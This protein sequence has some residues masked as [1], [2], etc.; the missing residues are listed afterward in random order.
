MESF[1]ILVEHLLN[2][3]LFVLAGTVWGSIIANNSGARWT[4]NDWGYLFLV[5]V[6]I[7]AIR[8]VCVGAFYPLLSRIG[9]GTCW[10]EAGFLGY[11]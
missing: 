9:L 10:Q 11:A 4:G 6:L 3:L 5:Y 8:F 7:N 2:T 1:W